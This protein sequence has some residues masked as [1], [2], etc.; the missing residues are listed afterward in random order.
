MRCHTKERDERVLE[1]FRVGQ[2]SVIEKENRPGKYAE[3]HPAPKAT[4]KTASENS[5]SLR[6]KQLCN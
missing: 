6:S 3:P 1:A 5:C 2:V 4:A